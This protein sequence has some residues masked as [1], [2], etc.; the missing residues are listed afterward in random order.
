MT[1]PTPNPINHLEFQVL[2]VLSEGVSY[3][4]AI[5][6]GIEEQSGGRY[7]PD[8]G[9]L[10][11]LLARLSARGLVEDKPAPKGAGFN[12]RGRPRNYY[13]LTPQG[14]EAVR[15]EAGHLERLVS[16][17]RARR[18]LAGENLP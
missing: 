13:G 1:D 5:M 17:A 7:R 2:L 8:V 11:R 9:S 4:Y 3:G 6:K 16:Q 10:Y 12:H 14:F 15:R 18:L